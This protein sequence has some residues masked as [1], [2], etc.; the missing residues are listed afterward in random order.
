MKYK[1]ICLFIIV[2]II[3][4]AISAQDFQSLKSELESKTVTGKERVD[5]LLKIVNAG[6]KVNADSLLVLAEEALYLAQYENYFAGQIAALFSIAD[7]YEDIAD[8]DKAMNYLLQ[9]KNIAIEE[10]LDE[11]IGKAIFFIAIDYIYQNEFDIAKENLLDTFLYF[12]YLDDKF[13]LRIYNNLANIYYYQ[14]DYAIALDYFLKMKILAESVNDPFEIGC[15]LT[16]IGN[17]YNNLGDYETSKNNYEEAARLFELS[18]KSIYLNSIHNNLGT[19]Y[20]KLGQPEKAKE[21]YQKALKS[22]LETDDNETVF[23]IY[24]NLGIIELIHT[25]D[26][27]KALELF[28]KAEQFAIIAGDDKDMAF[29][30]MNIGCAYKE[31]K[32]YDLALEFL[33]SAYNYAESIPADDL[34]VDIIGYILK[35]K[36]IQENN[37][38]IAELLVKYG[39][40]QKK[41]GAESII[42]VNQIHQEFDQQRFDKELELI[43]KEKE[44]NAI[45]IKHQK[46]VIYGSIVFL[47]ILT[48]ALIYVIHLNKKLR[49]LHSDLQRKVDENINKLRQQDS[50]LIMQNHQAAMGEMLSMI[51]HQWKQPL[52]SIG[53]IIQNLEDAYNF[54]EMSD[55]LIHQTTKDIMDLIYMM[56]NTISSFRDY[57]IMGKDEKFNVAEAIKHGLDYIQ[58]MLKKYDITADTDIPP[59]LFLFGQINLLVQVILVLASNSR[60]AFVENEINNRN[61]RIKAGK[62]DEEKIFIYFEDNAGGIP[63]NVIDKI[64]NP[65]FSTKDSEKG[66]GIGLYIC[67]SIVVQKF[68]GSISVQNI[69][70]GCRFILIFPPITS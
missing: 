65:Y 63:E 4:A 36:A 32:Q 45:K 13:K 53:I 44:Y 25:K 16:G 5:L 26:F 37:Q 67:N 35:I 17:I 51:A 14:I 55:E 70:D 64:F 23:F 48:A 1:I 59:E 7:Q 21:F 39:E 18:D 29:A 52:N 38:E 41:I 68:M 62:N 61:I 66:T 11:E 47:I 22:A 43:N 57:Y 60:D 24:N 8:N 6:K 49:F 33:Q 46:I 27:K 31:M 9:A 2:L 54:N 19:I 50:I 30:R 20:S 40:I 10:K 56:A 34:L 3:A 69:E 12:D 28:Q 58:V 42:K 15:A